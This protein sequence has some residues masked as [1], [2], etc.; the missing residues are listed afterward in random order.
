M[1]GLTDEA[2]QMYGWEH[3]GQWVTSEA[4]VM[5]LIAAALNAKADEIDAAAVVAMDTDEPIGYRAL[6][7]TG[8]SRAAEIVRNH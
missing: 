3:E 7:S 5:A 4:G 2:R 6:I 1:S 8:Y